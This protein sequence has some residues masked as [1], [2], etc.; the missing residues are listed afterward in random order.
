[1]K[2][3][4]AVSLLAALAPPATVTSYCHAHRVPQGREPRTYSRPL[5]NRAHPAAMTSLPNAIT[6]EVR[7]VDLP[8]TCAGEP[9]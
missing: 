5:G 4:I 8:G 1:M 7:C 9:I 2:T 6:V 3:I